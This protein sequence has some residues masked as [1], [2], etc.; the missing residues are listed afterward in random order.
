[1]LN[2]VFLHKDD[3]VT[4]QQF[5]AAFPDADTVEVISDTSSGI[6]A[7]TTATLHH[8]KVNGAVVS[9]SKNIVD[10]SSW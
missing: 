9:V 8:I 6:G 1:M 3:L 10:E 5:M 2:K 7:V 4:I